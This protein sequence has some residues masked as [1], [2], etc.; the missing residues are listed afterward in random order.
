VVQDADGDAGCKVDFD[1]SCSTGNIVSY[2]WRFTDDPPFIEVN[3]E[4]TTTYDWSDNPECGTP[5]SRLVRL[6][7]TAEG[8]AAAETQ[9]NINPTSP[10]GLK[11]LQNKVST[12]RTSFTSSLKP[13]T[14]VGRIDAQVVLNGNQ[15]DVTD[16]RTPYRHQLNGRAGTNTVEA[17]I[18]S[19]LQTQ[20][21]WQFDFA[22]A[23]GIVPNSLRVEMGSVMTKS[24]HSVTL[25]LSGAPGERIKLSFRLR[26][27]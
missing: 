20:V 9:S 23:E 24:S 21:F 11:T 17:Y 12:V 26:P 8:G 25:R 7:V 10:T 15:V 27:H 2:R 5:F 4:P 18:T 1:A 19:A 3:A 6:T 13:S 14:V 22:G 16:N